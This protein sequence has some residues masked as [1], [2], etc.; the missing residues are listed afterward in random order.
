MRHKVAKLKLNI[1][2]DHFTALRRNLATSFFCSGYIETTLV[3]ARLTKSVVEKLITKAK[4]QDLVTRRR[5]SSYLNTPQAFDNLW[6]SIALSY[7]NRPGGYTRLIKMNFRKGDN[8]PM[9]RLEL[10][11]NPLVNK[12][13]IE[14]VKKAAVSE[15]KV[16]EDK[17]AKKI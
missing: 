11:D 12:S 7:K 10:V 1:E 17:V 3:K 5:L 13:K 16:S 15:E 4:K 8:A 2:R 14:K 9:A 6:S